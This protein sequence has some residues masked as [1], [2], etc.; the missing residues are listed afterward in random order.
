MELF[1]YINIVAV[2]GVACF[3]AALH[4]LRDALVSTSSTASS[5]TTWSQV[6]ARVVQYTA[7][8]LTIAL[9]SVSMQLLGVSILLAGGMLALFGLGVVGLQV[10]SLRRWGYESAWLM[11]IILVGLILITYWPW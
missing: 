9:L 6:A 1:S 4:S 7:L 11:G 5:V 3:L 2:V 8:S 10:T